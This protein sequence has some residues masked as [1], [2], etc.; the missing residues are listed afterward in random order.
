MKTKELEKVDAIMRQPRKKQHKV[1][2]SSKRAG[3]SPKKNRCSNPSLLSV[4][5]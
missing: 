3:C 5:W 2:G 4:V 1:Q